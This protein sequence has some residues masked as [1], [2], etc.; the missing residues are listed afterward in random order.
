M[1]LDIVHVAL[2]SFI[3]SVYRNI[4]DSLIKFGGF[5]AQQNASRNL[6]RLR[7]LK[8]NSPVSS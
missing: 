2:F 1:R 8:S 7:N 4:C 6:V 3:I 5:S